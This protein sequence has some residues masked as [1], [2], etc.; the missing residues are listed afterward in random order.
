MEAKNDDDE[1][2]FEVE[3]A[4]V[5]LT[6]V[7]PPRR[8]PAIGK[9]EAPGRSKRKTEREREREK[10]KRLK[11][12]REKERVIRVSKKKWLEA[13]AELSSFSSFVSFFLL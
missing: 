11:K 9:V 10:G 1:E 6:P 7:P 4:S 3:G 12:K 5:V 13:A 8:R 2:G